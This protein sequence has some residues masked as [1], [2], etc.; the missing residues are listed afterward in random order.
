MYLKHTLPLSLLCLTFVVLSCS[1]RK[2]DPEKEAIVQ[3]QNSNGRNDAW[4]F[5]GAGGGGAMFHPSISPHNADLAFVSCDMT[6]SY[7]TENGGASWRMFNLRGGVDFYT[8]DPVDPK[9][10]Y[11]NSIA[12]F[13]SD[14]AGKTWN[15][16]YPDSSLI[17]GSVPK[18]DHA[19]EVLVTKDHTTRK[20]LALT[21]DPSDSKKLYAAISVN[22]RTGFYSSDDRGK[23]WTSEKVLEDDAQKIFVLPSS[24]AGNRTIYVAGK[25]TIAVRKDGKW[26]INKGPSGVRQLTSVSGGF[27]KGHDRFFIY[28]ISGKG[29]FNPEGDPSGI[30]VTEDGGATW[31]NRQNGLLSYQFTGAELPEY[32][33]VATSENYPEVIYVSYNDLHTQKDT[34]CMGVAKS[35][36]YGITWTLCWKDRTTA[37]HIQKPSPNMNDG[38][39]NERFGPS[40]GEN[41]FSLGVDPNDP[42]IC[43]GT[44]F[45]RALKTEDGGRQW[46][47][48]YTNRSPQGW[49][50]R[51]LEV[52]TSYQV[53]FDPF[54]QQHCF[55]A[56]TDIGLMESTDGGKSWNSATNKNGIPRRWENSTYWIVLDPAVK[57]KM[58]AA[59][60]GTHDLPR[61]KMWRRRSVNDF[62][63]GVVTSEDGGK[64]WK[65]LSADLGESA[66][67]HLLLDSASDPSSRTLYACAF[68]KGV[69]KSTDG[70]KTWQKKNKGLPAT[71]PFAWRLEKRP[72]DGTLF[73]V[74]ARRNDDGTIGN[75]NDGA[76]YRSDDGAD[77]WTKVTLPEGTD[78]PMSLKV[79]PKNPGTLLLSAWGRAAQ[80]PYAPDTDGGIYR[81][82][83]DGK[84]W[85]H[86][87]EHDPHI[88]DITYDARTNV[89][90]ACGFNSSAYRS[91]D[92]GRSWQRIRGYNFKW[93]KRV[94]LDPRDAEKVFIITFGGGVWYGPAKGD[95]NA[96][97]D[98]VTKALSY[99]AR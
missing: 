77:T 80:A 28:A 91:E 71:E 92:S 16:V 34:T 37:N 53:A 61:P 98:I 25:N 83:D 85:S 88:H 48:V 2:P 86:V 27:D 51:G 38:W 67:T 15:V 4:G 60:S 29:Y 55:I 74:L 97:E 95:G 22:D 19:E 47:Q 73:L 87:L 66:V 78:G 33:A 17:E 3:A 13:R 7:V 36:D 20:V 26:S 64:S 50:S 40:W 12:L 68:G 44:D 72:A 32:R 93:G 45:G 8:F 90:Y 84:T 24:P 9:V 59:M 82:E 58:W 99:H 30:Y 14:D 42:E 57:N 46:G 18:G 70:G 43:Y 75:E 39:I 23:S 56:T 62:T 21:V 96:T 54:D 6:G 69:F 5:V 41:P 94:E 10:V 63:G 65:P 35:N 31:S 11:A 81:S 89:F 52:T 76:V 79:D 1:E 49:T